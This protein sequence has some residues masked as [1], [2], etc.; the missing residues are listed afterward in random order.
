[1]KRWLCNINSSVKYVKLS[2]HGAG[3]AGCAPGPRGNSSYHLT[4][5]CALKILANRTEPGLGFDICWG[6]L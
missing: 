2:A 6:I 1:M 3:L 5:N 4:I